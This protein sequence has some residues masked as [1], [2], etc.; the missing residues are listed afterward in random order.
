M[1]SKCKSSLTSSDSQ[2][3]LT[4]QGGR[5]PGEHS[6]ARVIDDGHPRRRA[7]APEHLALSALE[8]TPA[9]DEDVVVDVEWSG[10][11]TGTERLLWSGRMPHFPGMGYPLVPGYES[12]GRVRRGRAAL[13]CAGS[14]SACSFPV[15][16]ASA[17]SA[18][19]SAVPPRAVVV[20]GARVVPIDDELGEQ[21]VLLALAAT[22]YHAIAGAAARSLT[23]R[24]PRRARPAA[25][26]ARGRCTAATPVVWET[27]PAARRR[28][29]RA[30]GSSIRPSDD[31]PRLPRDLRRQRRPGAARHA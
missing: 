30:T 29:C 10:I 23:D 8:L 13:R 5:R 1:P 4:H 19:C 27:Q 22:A 26:A 25:G 12:V 14:A 17:R 20:P 2:C 21:G 3:S 16:A 9:G 31:A 24:R 15:R 18:A 11:S 6:W 7:E 28:R